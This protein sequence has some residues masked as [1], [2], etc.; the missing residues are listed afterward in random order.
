MIYEDASTTTNIGTIHTAC[1]MPPKS[2]QKGHTAKTRRDDFITLPILVLTHCVQHALHLVVEE[3]GRVVDEG[4]VVLVGRLD[5]DVVLHTS[6]GRSNVLDT[7]LEGAV[8]VVSEGEEGVRGYHDVVHLLEPLSA[9]RVVE[10]RGRL[11]EQGLEAGTVHVLAHSAAHVHIDSVGTVGTLHLLLELQVEDEG[12]LAEP[13]VVSLL[14]SKACAVDAG[15]LACT[16]TNNLAVS[17]VADRVGL[18]VLEGNG[19]NDQVTHGGLGQ[20]LVLGHDVSEEV[21]GDLEVV[22][23]LLH[24]DAEQLTG[25]KQRGLVGGVHRED[26]VLAVLL[27]LEDLESCIVVG[28]RNHTIRNLTRDDLSSGGIAS[29]R[30]GDPVTEG[31]HAVSPAG[32][33]VG[34]SEGGEILQVLNHAEL[35]LLWGEGGSHRGTSRGHVLE[36]S[37]RWQSSGHAQLLDELPSVEGVAEVNETGRAGKH[38]NRQ[39]ALGGEDL[40]GLLVGVHAV[41]QGQLLLALAVLATQVVRDGHVILGS[42]VEGLDSQSLAELR[43]G[44]LLVGGSKLL[45]DNIVVRGV[46]DDRHALVVLRSSTEQGHA[47]DINVLNSISDRHALLGNGLLEGVEV[48]HNDVDVLVATGSHVSI[49]AGDVTGKNTSVNG[50]VEGLHTTTEHLGGLGDVGN[51]LNRETGISNGGGG[52]T[53]GDELDTNGVDLLSEVNKAGLVGHT[54]KSDSLNH[55]DVGLERDPATIYSHVLC[56][57]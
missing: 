45:S 52:T 46:H 41:A 13:P 43:G 40:C 30:E 19:G 49:V 36:G 32:T 15:L 5:D 17:G 16:K 47:A 24:V 29:V 35:S 4:H 1:S 51:I 7:T 39:V 55:F 38:L 34:G 37:R 50:R 18:S 21:L 11:L 14:P 25:L 3:A 8:D 31:G 26:S 42:V 56:V 2:P 54:Q 9:G 10:S 28:R 20:L 27:L 57:D 23:A 33:C 44:V 12:V 22:A 48:A 53:R 6:A